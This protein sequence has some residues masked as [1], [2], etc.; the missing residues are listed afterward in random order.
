MYI[1]RIILRKKIHSSVNSVHVERYVERE[2]C[3][4]TSTSL[5]CSR[6]YVRTKSLRRP[7]K[8]TRAE[9]RSSIVAEIRGPPAKGRGGGTGEFAPEKT[10]G[11][12]ERA[13]RRGK[14]EVDSP[15]CLDNIII[16]RG[17]KGKRKEA[18][19]PASG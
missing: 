1:V 8:E 13:K 3:L 9:T 19:G 6:V 14:H 11:G 5:L 15:L 12:G 4:F 7:V 2:S 17:P 16:E 18:E 10:R